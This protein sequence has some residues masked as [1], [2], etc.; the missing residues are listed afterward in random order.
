MRVGCIYGESDA[1]GASMVWE[2]RTR[3]KLV[4]SATVVEEMIRM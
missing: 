4:A 3:K 1:E 2:G